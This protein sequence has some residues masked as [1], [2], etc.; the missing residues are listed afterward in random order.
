MTRYDRV[1]EALGGYGEFV[2][3]PREIRPALQRAFD[4]GVPACINVPT[5]FTNPYLAENHGVRW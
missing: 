2:E 5:E 1:A 3:D 4:S